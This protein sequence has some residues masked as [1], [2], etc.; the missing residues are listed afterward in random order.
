MHFSVLKQSRGKHRDDYDY[1]HDCI[2]EWAG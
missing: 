2:Y 1:D